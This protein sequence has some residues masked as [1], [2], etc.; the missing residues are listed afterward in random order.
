MTGQ[1]T[2]LRQASAKRYAMP[3]RIHPSRT[4]ETDPVKYHQRHGY[5]NDN[6]KGRQ[7]AAMESDIR[8]SMHTAADAIGNET[9]RQSG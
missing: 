4:D 8:I 5:R 7:Y 9:D 1:Y 2:K 3:R 6:Q